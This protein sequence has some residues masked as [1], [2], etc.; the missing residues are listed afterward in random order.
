MLSDTHSELLAHFLAGRPLLWSWLA[1]EAIYQKRVVDFANYVHAVAHSHPDFDP[2]V[3]IDS[4]A[5]R[6]CFE[7]VS[8]LPRDLVK[9]HSDRSDAR[10]RRYRT[11]QPHLLAAIGSATSLGLDVESLC[12]LKH[13]G[14]E[15]VR[16]MGSCPRAAGA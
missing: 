3:G 4:F 16:P 1:A 2:D 8:A 7:L 10:D 5:A 12:Y 14:E 6:H 13:L 11:F 9:E 15:P